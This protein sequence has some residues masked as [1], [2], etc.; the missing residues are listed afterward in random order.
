M[1]GR[2]LVDTFIPGFVGEPGDRTFYLLVDDA[3][4]RSWYLLEKGQVAA[5]AMESGQLLADHELVTAGDELELGDMAAPDEV[6]FRVADISLAYEED[7]TVAVTVVSTDDAAV[8]VIHHLTITQLGAAARVAV[9]AVMAGRPR[10]PRCGLAMDAEGHH[11]PLTNGDL[12]GH[13]P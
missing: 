6:A 7:G 9:T 1:S 8:T 4:A 3:G 5:F 10:C 12:R 2:R 11:C 13:R